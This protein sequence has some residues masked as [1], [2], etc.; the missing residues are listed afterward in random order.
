[1]SDLRISQF[2]FVRCTIYVQRNMRCLSV[3]AR[4]L[5]L[6]DARLFQQKCSCR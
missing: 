4:I 5:L 6:F 1:V 3:T 2:I